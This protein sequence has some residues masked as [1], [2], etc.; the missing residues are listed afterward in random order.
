MFLFAFPLNDYRLVEQNYTSIIIYLPDRPILK[1]KKETYAISPPSPVIK[2]E[3]EFVI[4]P[5][6]IPPV[7]PIALPEVIDLDSFKYEMLQLASTYKGELP[8]RRLYI[9][10]VHYET[11]PKTFILPVALITAGALASQT[12]DFRDFI[13]IPR[14]DG[15]IKQNQF[16]DILQYVVPS[17]LFVYD[18]IAKEKHHPV[19]QF[20]VMSV[21]YG[22]T[23]LQVRSIKNYLDED[24]PD[25]GKY[26]FPSGHT[27]VAFVGGHMIYKEFKDTNPWIAYSG[28]VMAGAVGAGRMINNRHW[29]SDVVAGAGFAILSTEL[30]YFI[31]FP[32]RNLITNEANKLLGKY[33]IIGPVLRP[34]EVGLR[35][36]MTF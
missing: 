24:R 27:A 25:G 11:N 23:A 3:D 36:N 34:D 8:V 15:K 32:V 22:L 26:S 30:A 16:D 29:L 7:S 2:K 12:K 35:V 14:P 18:I 9:P 20:F 17:S 19:D 13:H 4:L 10:P 5:L 6:D 31:Y 1:P 28:Y 33:F 21:S